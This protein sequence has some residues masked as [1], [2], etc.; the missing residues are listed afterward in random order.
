M[1]AND[2]LFLNCTSLLRCLIGEGDILAFIEFASFVEVGQV[3]VMNDE[4]ILVFNVTVHKPSLM[5][6]IKCL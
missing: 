3:E 2:F 1:R 5:Q 6:I 4:C